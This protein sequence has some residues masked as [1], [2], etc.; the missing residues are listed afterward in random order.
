LP[1]TGHTKS[2]SKA[3]REKGTA[4]RK[5][6]KQKRKADESNLQAKRQEMDKNKAR[7]SFPEDYRWSHFSFTQITDAVKRYSYLLGQ[8]DL[9]KHFVD[10]KASY[11]RFS[12][13]KSEQ[14]LIESSGSSIC[15]A[16]RFPTQAKR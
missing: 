1:Q 5:Q 4:E 8:T 12:N 16:V 11:T 15:R 7:T 13:P 14:S 6:K 2:P 10:I 3:A 9:F